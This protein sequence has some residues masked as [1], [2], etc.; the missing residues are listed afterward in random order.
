LKSSFFYSGKRYPARGEL[1]QIYFDACR[2]IA[3]L[4]TCIEQPGCTN[5]V[6]P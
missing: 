1:R 5:A 2:S 3:D 6:N 4:A